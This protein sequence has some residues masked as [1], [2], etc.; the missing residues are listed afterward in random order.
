LQ[1]LGIASVTLAI[2]PWPKW[3]LVGLTNENSMG[4]LI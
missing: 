1:V 2:L 3:I 4:Y